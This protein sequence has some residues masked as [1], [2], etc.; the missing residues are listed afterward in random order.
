MTIAVPEEL[1]IEDQVDKAL[2]DAGPSEE[3]S[4][5]TDTMAKLRRRAIVRENSDV[6][7]S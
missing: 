7:P 5:W 4:L 1:A 3:A 2:A 6:V